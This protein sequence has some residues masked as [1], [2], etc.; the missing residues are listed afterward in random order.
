MARSAP[1]LIHHPPPLF[2]AILSMQYLIY[3][4]CRIGIHDIRQELPDTNSESW[5]V[6]CSQLAQSPLSDLKEPTLDPPASTLTWDFW[7]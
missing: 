6:C 2:L 3:V 5:D 4:L 1:T 7:R